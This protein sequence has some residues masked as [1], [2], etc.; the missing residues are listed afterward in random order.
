MTDRSLDQKI[1]RVEELV[2][3]LANLGDPVARATAQDLMQT[4]LS[5]HRTGLARLLEIVQQSADRPAIAAAI[6]QDKVLASL[7]LLHDL[8]PVE[9]ATRVSRA[10]EQ[11][12]PL[13]RG[14]GGDLEL[15]AIV[16]KRVRV[17]LNGECSL[18]AEALEHYLEEAFSA[19]APDVQAIEV[20]DPTRGAQIRLPLP[21]L[22]GGE[23]R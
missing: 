11:V 23:P 12:R 2:D 22:A 15:V 19:A 18:T 14:H 3:T 5:L 21:I 10:L 4:L 6:E 1:G 17:R 13:I 7:L 16:G 20:E 9:L 8:H